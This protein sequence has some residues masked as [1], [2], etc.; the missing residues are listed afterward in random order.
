MRRIGA[1]A[2]RF[3]ILWSRVEPA[4]GCWDDGAW[5]HYVDEV[6]RLRAAGIAP[7]ITLHH[8][9]LPRWLARRL[10]F[11]VPGFPRLDEPL[12]ELAGSADWFCLNDYTRDMVRFSLAAPGRTARTPGPGART[13]TPS[14]GRRR[15]VCRC[16][17]GST[18]RSPTTSSGPRGSSRASGS[19]A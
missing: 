4:P 16:A 14:P 5:A 13:S 3:S 10:R 11:A 8:S 18:G 1:N 17:A 15:R 7:M 9:T 2:Y 19:T 6:E 12:P